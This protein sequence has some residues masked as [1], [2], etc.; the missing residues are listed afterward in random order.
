MN[1]INVKLLR[2]AIEQ[3]GEALREDAKRSEG[4]ANEQYQIAGARGLEAMDSE[5][6]VALD[7]GSFARGLACGLGTAAN[8]LD[9]LLAALTEDP[10]RCGR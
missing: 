10:E 1:S 9:S 3:A 6:R 7:E 5:L 2:F 8:K 4:R